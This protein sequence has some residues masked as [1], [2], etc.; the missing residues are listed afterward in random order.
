MTQ[1][2]FFFFLYF[3]LIC[4]S[5]NLNRNYYKFRYLTSTKIKISYFNSPP[6]QQ[7]SCCL[8]KS[9]YGRSYVK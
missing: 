1:L 8:E 3:T 2:S 5:V 6:N 9:G 7:S 4:V